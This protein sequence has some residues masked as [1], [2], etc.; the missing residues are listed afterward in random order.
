[1]FLLGF[2]VAGAIVA[3]AKLASLYDESWAWALIGAA[4]V[5]IV[6]A[7]WDMTSRRNRSAT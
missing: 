3:V 1:M 2:I 7:G 4:I 6:V 5:A